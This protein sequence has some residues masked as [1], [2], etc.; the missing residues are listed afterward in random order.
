MAEVGAEYRRQINDEGYDPDHDDTHCEG[1]LACAAVAYAMPEWL[2]EW[3]DKNDI[4]IWPFEGHPK[5]KDKSRDLI[6]AGALLITDIARLDCV[7]AMSEDCRVGKECVK[8]C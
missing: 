1:E 6:R 8:T 7:V 5:F 2:N 3:M 4:K